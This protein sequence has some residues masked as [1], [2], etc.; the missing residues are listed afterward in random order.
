MDEEEEAKAQQEVEEINS[1][2]NK[3]EKVLVTA[4]EA[5]MGKRRSMQLLVRLLSYRFCFKCNQIK[6]PRT[7]HCSCCN[8]CIV[9]MDH[10]CPW[11]GGC[12]AFRNHKLFVLFLIYTTVGCLYAF[13]TMGLGLILIYTDGDAAN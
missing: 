11:V 1:F 9:K 6:P 2:V 10:H 8:R 3:Q 5:K 7:H 4:L 12:V 13:F